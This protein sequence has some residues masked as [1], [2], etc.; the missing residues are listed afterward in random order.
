MPKAT[1]KFYVVWIGRKSGLYTSWDETAKQ[2]NGFPGAK[3]KSFESRAQAE[4]AF[5][6]NWQDYYQTGLPKPARPLELGQ[7]PS[8]PRLPSLTVDASCIGVPGPTEYRGVDTETRQ[9][10][11]RSEIY[12]HGT[13]NVGEFL[14]IVDGLIWLAERTD[15]RPLYSDSAT[16]LTWIKQKICRTTLTWS[17]RN[18][19]LKERVADAESWLASHTYT[20]PILKWET[21]LWGENPADFGRK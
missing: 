14:A 8:P 4:A 2:V 15:P 10:L 16:A 6:G 20:T 12:Q 18:A 11:F 17:A 5:R 21:D 19:R 7:Q 9:E 3:Y 1:S 13:N